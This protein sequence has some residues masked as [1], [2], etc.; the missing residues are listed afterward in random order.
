MA[1][2]KIKEFIG[3]A[4]PIVGSLFG[5]P[6]GGAVGALVASTL[7]VENE[8]EAILEELKSNPDAILKIKQMESDERKQL[9]ELEYKS[10][11]AKLNDKQ[12]QHEQTQ[13]TIRNGDN[14]TDME[15]RRTRPHIAKVSFYSGAA[16]VFILE[17]IG[18]YGHGSGASF[19][20]AGVLFSPVLTYMGLRT[21]DAFSPKGKTGEAVRAV[22]SFIE[23]G[24]K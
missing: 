4:A 22:T 23:G 10:E 2:N 9:R 15:V 13:L 1:W 6:V 5:G 21:V 18:A 8:P 17:L 3:G 24:K 19:E 16:Y 20:M 12:A 14:A 11:I 7:G